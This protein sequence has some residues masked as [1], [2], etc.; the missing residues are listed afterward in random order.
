MIVTCVHVTVKKE[1]IDDFIEETIANHTASVQEPGNLRFDVLQSSDDPCVFMLYEA[2]ESAGLGPQDIELAEVHDAMAPGEMFRIEKLDLCTAADMGRFV[3][4][5]YFTLKGKLPVNS[6]GGLASR[7]HPIG[8]TGLAQI[9][10]LVC[11]LRGEAGPRQVKGRSS[12]YPKVALAQ[13]SGGNVEDGS[14]ALTV[15]ILER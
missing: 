11:Q 15:T 7:G 13:N 6:S 14:A 8:A 2:Y 1:H 12:P 3:D 5:E 9:F 10:E 4:E